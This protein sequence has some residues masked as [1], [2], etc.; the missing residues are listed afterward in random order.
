MLDSLSIKKK[1]RIITIAIFVIGALAIA[2]QATLVRSEISSLEKLKKLT[3]LSTKLALLVHE[4]QKERGASAGF[5]GSHGKTFGQKLEK[6][7]KT[8]DRRLKAYHDYLSSVSKNHFDKE[9]MA[10][11]VGLETYLKKLP[12]I[13]RRIDTL[14]IPLK[15]AIDFYTAMNKAML[16]IVPST[17]KFSP[18]A[19]L[20]NLL[21]SYANFLKSKERAGV[22]RAVLSGAFASGG[23]APGM[24][25]KEITLI[26]EQNSY[27]DAFLATAPK[28]IK[29][30]YEK[31]YKGSE[32]E[33]VDRMRKLAL[34]AHRF[35]T[36]PIHW[37][38][39][40]TKKIDI[41][42]KIDDHISAEAF[43]T[44]ADLESEAKKDA[45]ANILLVGLVVLSFALMIYFIAKNIVLNIDSLKNQ[46]NDLAKTMD[47]SKRIRSDSEG[48]LAQI[49]ASF[50]RLLES[51]A[52]MIDRTKRN[53][54]QTFHK[55]RE[56]K[57][58]ANRLTENIRKTEELFKDANEL[59][60]DVGGN[61]DITEEHVI[62]TTEV[63]ENTQ[64][65]LDK[66]VFDLQKSVEMIY[67]GNE[68][69]A[70]L[71][72]QMNELNA[73]ASQI[74]NIISIIGDIADQ[75]NLLALN[76]AIE[77]ARA[78]E[79]GRG[80]AVVADE[81]RQLAERTQ[82]SLSEINLNINIITQN[83][84]TIGS[85]IHSTS[86][87]FTRIAQN[88]DTLIENANDTKERLKDSVNIS[89][90]SVQKTTYIAQ[91]TKTLIG[92]MDTLL[93]IS[94]NNKEAGEEVNSV[95]EI[96]AEKSSELNEA[97]ETFRL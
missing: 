44:I 84:D 26:A 4:T 60:H 19:K 87:D 54:D 36:D 71:T 20:A 46:I 45:L 53:S 22:E 62:K 66:F 91:K 72:T 58:T 89:V 90:K 95:S 59:I 94:Q 63:L 23:F 88:A 6:Q 64:K 56:L 21:G 15:E 24:E 47:L 25:K 27:L 38:D 32:I 57:G 97:L 5:L 11:I 48:E 10:Q 42:K 61:L 96:L 33:E 35:D 31:T 28:E 2:H 40:I 78:G 3:T 13:R 85:E 37:F 51:F 8:T 65:I 17:A 30:F 82:K 29:A 52:K 83:I 76:A 12:K 39:T 80:F 75:T 18:N 68:R 77:A 73:Q 41:L 14:S 81:V 1:L 93:K 55:S 34:D 43:T 79:H 67:A 7:R 9:I 49:A 69:Q 86:K 74:K 50:N 70:S 92:E 16:D